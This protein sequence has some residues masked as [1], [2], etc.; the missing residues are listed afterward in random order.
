MNVSPAPVRTAAFTTLDIDVDR[1]ALYCTRDVLKYKISYADPVRRLAINAVVR[2]HD[3]DAIVVAP[4][5]G[6]VTVGD[7]VHCSVGTR[8]GLDSHRLLRILHDSVAKCDISYGIIVVL[9]ANGSNGQAMA[10]R[11]EAILED[12]V[13][14]RVDGYAVVLIPDLRSC[15]QDAVCIV[16]VE[17]IRILSQLFTSLVVHRDVLHCQVIDVVETEGILRRILDGDGVQKGVVQVVGLFSISHP[18]YLVKNGYAYTKGLMCQ[19]NLNTNIVDI[20]QSSE[21]HIP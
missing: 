21:N 3:D 1:I 11:T 9:P 10:T 15:N 17:A 6:N 5:H 18:A 2:L 12:Y 8:N 4:T 19:V 20:T 16:D 7:A 14:A 13:L